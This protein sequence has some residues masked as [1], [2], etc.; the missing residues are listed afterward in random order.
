MGDSIDYWSTVDTIKIQQSLGIFCLH[1]DIEIPSL[2]TEK[3]ACFDLKAYLKTGET[4]IG[5][6]RYNHKKEISLEKDSLEMLPKWRYLIPTGMIFDIPSGYYVKVHPRSG[7]ALKKGLITAN[8]VGIIDEDYVEECNCIM[9]NISH[10]T[11]LVEHG[12]RIAQAEMRRTE[13]YAIGRINKRPE[14]KTERDGGF[15]ST[16][17]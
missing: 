8:N 10:D 16:G 2:A 3:S 12:D 9:I 7:N 11:I 5:Y 15:G 4:I 6:N 14:Q 17:I 13:H 1:D